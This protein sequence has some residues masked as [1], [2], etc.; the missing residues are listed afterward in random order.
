MTK[1]ELLVEGMGFSMSRATKFIVD[2]PALLG[3]SRYSLWSLYYV[4]VSSSSYGMRI[5]S[6]S[7][8]MHVSSSSRYSLSVLII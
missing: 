4:H 2:T 6:S 7:Y 5:S 8:G 1:M 3:R